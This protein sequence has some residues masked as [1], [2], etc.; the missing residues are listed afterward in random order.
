MLESEYA[1]EPFP[2]GAAPNREAKSTIEVLYS[3]IEG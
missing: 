3:D 2:A 1:P